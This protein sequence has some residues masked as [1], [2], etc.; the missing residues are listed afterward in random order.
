MKEGVNLRN[1]SR[2][3]DRIEDGPD[4]TIK[5]KRYGMWGTMTE[6]EVRGRKYFVVHPNKKEKEF[7]RLIDAQIYLNDFVNGIS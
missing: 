3:T 2:L 6:I 4:G 1:L 7:K 5:I